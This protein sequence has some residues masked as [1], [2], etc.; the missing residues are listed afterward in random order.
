MPRGL[1]AAHLLKTSLR[2]ERVA[3]VPGAPFFAVE[4]DAAT[5]RLSY[6]LGGPD[7][8]DE[9]VRRLARVIASRTA[10]AA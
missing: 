3:F 7:D 9:G 8:I 1:D 5:L 10:Q 4:P 2:E 6:S